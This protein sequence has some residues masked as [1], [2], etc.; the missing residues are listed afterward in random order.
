MGEDTNRIRRQLDDTR[1][2]LGDDRPADEIRA[3]I[4][5]T[6]SQMGDT[7]GALGHKADVK[8]RMSDSISRK[9]NALFGAV[10]SGKDAVVGGADRIVSTVTGAAP[11]TRQVAEGARKVGVSKQSPVGLV[12]AGGAAGLL[13]GLLV[14]STH[15]E[16]ERIGEM[17]EQVKDTVKETGSEALERGKQVAQDTASAASDSASRQGE[18]LTET[19]QDNVKQ[20]EPTRAGGGAA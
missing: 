18:E 16:D 4:E 15:M 3:D 19:L 20:A 12:V 6:R 13:V 11:D 1:A 14:P 5:Q 7:M 8:G 10:G 9:K 2:Q 17:A